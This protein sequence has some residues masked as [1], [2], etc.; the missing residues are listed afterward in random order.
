MCAQ[1]VLF[2]PVDA[3]WLHMEHPT[4]LMMITGIVLL[5]G[6]IDLPA[7]RA[8]YAERLLEF[9]RFRQ[10]AVESTLG[11]G[12]PTWEDDEHFDLDAHIHHIALPNPGDRGQLLDLLSDLS[13]TPLDY[14]KPLWQMHAV[15]NV[16]GGSAVIMR[17]HHSIGDG[18]ALVAVIMRLMDLEA[19]GAAA[20]PLAVRKRKRRGML[21]SLADGAGS[22]ARGAQSVMGTMLHEGM[23]SLVH[24]SR[25]IELS[26]F[27]ARAAL[28][29]ASTA[30]HALTQPNDPLTVFKGPLGVSKRVAWSEALR[31]DEVKL[32]AHALDAKVNDVLVSTMAGALRRYMVEHGDEVANLD[33]R[34]IIPVDMRPVERALDLGNAFGLIFLPMPV[35]IGDAGARLAEVKRRMDALKQSGGAVLYYGLLNVFGMTPKQ[36]EENAVEFFAARATTVFTNVAG[37]RMQ[38]YLA[39]K[40]VTDCLFWVPQSGRLGMGI[41]IMSYN[42]RVSLG[43]ITDT[44]LVPDPERIAGYFAEEYAR[45]Q[46]V[47]QQAQAA[48]DDGRDRPLCAALN[49]NGAPCRNRAVP[50]HSYCAR[51]RA[52]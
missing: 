33:I 51:H 38:L 30:G 11:F 16:E 6:A 40:T 32:V 21:R 24:P 36:V 28:Q 34:A 25:L 29:G 26:Q 12:R 44:G 31:V 23:E 3:A 4:N 1:S 7:L 27:A 5:E 47:A 52:R 19:D 39:G 15:D 41:S 8:V 45:L 50:G 18:T 14:T 37:P 13:S 10:R 9:R 22:V 43:I 46:R 42:G 49:R 20:A 48:R 2:S 35:G 17:I